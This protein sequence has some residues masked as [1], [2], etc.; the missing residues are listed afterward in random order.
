MRA[1]V[2]I[3]VLGA[4]LSG[5]A[6]ITLPIKVAGTAGGTAVRVVT[7]GPA[8]PVELPSASRH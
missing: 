8:D 6:L 2:L 1:L 3:T 5:C 7:Q 4:M